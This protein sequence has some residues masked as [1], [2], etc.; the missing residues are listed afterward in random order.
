MKICVL[1]AEIR[2]DDQK[3]PSGLKTYELFSELFP[4]EFLLIIF[5]SC[6]LYYLN[7]LQYRKL[8]CVGLGMTVYIYKFT[9]VHMLGLM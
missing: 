4:F 9:S 3:S 2:G 1:C 7:S 6:H 8:H 5:L